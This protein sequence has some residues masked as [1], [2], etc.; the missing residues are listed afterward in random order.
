MANLVTVHY[1][2]VK[3][4]QREGYL[5]MERNLWKPAHELLVKG[6]KIRSWSLYEV[7]GPSASDGLT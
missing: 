7:N 4:G 6:T 3:P 1:L 2:K 5:R